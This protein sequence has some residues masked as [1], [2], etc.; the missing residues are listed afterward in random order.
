MSIAA[1]RQSDKT[2]SHG[3]F[4]RSVI[5]RRSSSSRIPGIR[6]SSA[7]QRRMRSL[8]SPSILTESATLMLPFG[9]RH[10][11]SRLDLNS[12]VARSNSNVTQL[13]CLDAVA[14][15]FVDGPVFAR[16][17]SI[18]IRARMSRSSPSS[19]RAARPEFPSIEVAVQHAVRQS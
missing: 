13:S 15:S 11:F 3:G 9:S 18:S 8:D 4:H 6:E 10:S 7:T 12:D 5:M 1:Q 2:S 17:A 16:L 14:T 19:I